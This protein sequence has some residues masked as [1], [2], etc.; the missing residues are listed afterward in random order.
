MR[1]RGYEEAERVA[2]GVGIKRLVISDGSAIDVP[3][4]GVVAIVGPNNSG[5]SVALREIY[6]VLSTAHVQQGVR[7]VVRELE[8][9]KTGTEDELQE[10]LEKHCYAT[11]V[12]SAPGVPDRN[13]R[14]LNYNVSWSGI[15]HEWRTSP[16][17]F[18]IALAQLF[19][20]FGDA[21]QRLSLI[22][23]SSLWNPMTDRP[24]NPMQMFYERP[25]LEQ[26]ISA[27]CEEAFGIPLTL[28]RIPG[29]SIDLYLGKA[30]V[31]PSLVPSEEY[32]DQFRRMP[33][34]AAQGD[35]MRSFMGL[36][37]ALVATSYLLIILDEPEAFLHP[38]QA[39][40]LGRKLAE[41]ATGNAQVVLSTHSLDVLLGLLSARDANVTVVRMTR[42]GAENPVAIL[43]ADELR[44]LWRDPLLR[45]SNVLDGLFHRG[46]ILCEGDT[47]TRYYGAVLEELPGAGQSEFLLTQCGGKARMASIV[48]ALRAVDIPVAVIADFDVLRE[49]ARIAGLAEAL[50]GDWDRLRADWRVLDA[51][52]RDRGYRPLTSQVREQVSEV[53]DQAGARL[54]RDEV[55]RI[56]DVARVEDGW[57]IVRRGGIGDVPQG[58]ASERGQ[59]LIDQLAAL[60]LFVVPVGEVE[61]WEP[62]V[63]GEGPAWVN[64]VLE[65]NRHTRADAPVREF[66]RGVLDSFS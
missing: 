51:A 33:Q 32:L 5:K 21:M 6:S 42:R 4:T 52:V 14:R 43:R 36:M 27:V 34:L 62:G 31:A 59:S 66:L 1:N 16:N 64:A 44:S 37:I 63:P 58:D 11:D 12:E 56:R 15:R 61:R 35:G 19:V 8:V 49:E 18:G 2:F 28:S 55:K 39:R 46:V 47:D 54:E 41:E 53:L 45:H 24:S 26:R 60:R 57:S 25:E 30:D 3:T 10:W 48:R 38:P 23:G 29:G 13:Y 50:G 17:R 40:L 9:E 22:A 65:S 20:L 7:Q